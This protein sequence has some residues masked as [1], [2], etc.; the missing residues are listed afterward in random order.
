MMWNTLEQGVELGWDFYLPVILF[1][2]LVALAVPVWAAI[3]SA[4]ILMLILSG[5]CRSA[6]SARA[7]STA[8]ITSP[9]R[10]FAVYPDRRR[11]GPNG[12]VE[13]VLGRG[14]G[15]NLLGQGRVR[16]CDGARLRDVRGDLGIGRCGRRGRRPNDHRPSCGERLPPP[17]CLRPGRLGRLHGHPDPT[18]D[19]VHHHRFGA[20]RERLDPVLG[21]AD[22]GASDPRLDPGHKH[23]H[24][25]PLC[26]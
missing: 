18:V 11:P 20:W 3:G 25:P 12:S 26:L 19:C 16:L 1:V 14:R 13:E 6:W 10:R 24:Q 21:R 9:S 4:A 22:P 2:L 5:R 8:S 23:H 15:H 17:L 7:C